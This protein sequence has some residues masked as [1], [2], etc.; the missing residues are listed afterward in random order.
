M[1]VGPTLKSGSRFEKCTFA[2]IIKILLQ[3]S[4][5]VLRCCIGKS[6]IFTKTYRKY[7]I[8]NYFLI[9]KAS[10]FFTEFSKHKDI[11]LACL[12]IFAEI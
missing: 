12:A 3:D 8:F 10:F 11:F 9:S 5:D 4:L 6:H 1:M 7:N 2:K